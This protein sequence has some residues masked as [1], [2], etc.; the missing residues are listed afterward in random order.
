MPYA[1][2]ASLP[3]SIYVK[4]KKWGER[5]RERTFVI[6]GQW[7]SSLK[8]KFIQDGLVGY[9]VQLDGF[10]KSALNSQPMTDDARRKRSLRPRMY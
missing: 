9:G 5:S 8:R 2:K 6:Y 3:L 1:K 7:K 10:S 4:M